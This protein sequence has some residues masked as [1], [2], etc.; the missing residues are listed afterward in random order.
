MTVPAS[1]GGRRAVIFIFWSGNNPVKYTDPDGRHDETA[2]VFYWHI[3][4]KFNDDSS[5][6]LLYS[7]D[8]EAKDKHENV[9]RGTFTTDILPEGPTLGSGLLGTVQ[10][11][12][13]ELIS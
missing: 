13:E 8:Y 11:I 10:I 9:S 7:G 1:P 2:I 3:D 12:D 4:V 6:S 5:L